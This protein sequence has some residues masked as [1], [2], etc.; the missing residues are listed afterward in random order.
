MVAVCPGLINA[1][2]TLSLS[3]GLLCPAAEASGW[4]FRLPVFLTAGTHVQ[5]SEDATVRFDALSAFVELRLWTPYRPWSTSM[6]V[7]YRVSSD[8]RVADTLKTGLLF[9]H[10]DSDWDT[11]AAVFRS[12]PNGRPRSWGHA[13]RIRYR[14]AREHKIG[15]ESFGNHRQLE[16]AYLMLGYYRDLS[17]AFSVQLVAGSQVEGRHDRAARMEIVWQIN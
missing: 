6:F 1:V 16:A 8:D 17:S 10:Q 14:L 7:D 12:E 5:E 11:L 2:A 15:I 4:R 9:R 13:G 3:C